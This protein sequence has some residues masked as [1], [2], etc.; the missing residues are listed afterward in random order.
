MIILMPLNGYMGNNWNDC[1]MSCE[2][3]CQL[4]FLN[5]RH[6]VYVWPGLFVSQ[7]W[8]LWCSTAVLPSNS[9]L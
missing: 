2:C 4:L 5:Y 9:M 1:L 7:W 6:Q 8:L 3:G